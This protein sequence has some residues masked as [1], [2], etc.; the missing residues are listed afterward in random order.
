MSVYLKKIGW[1]IGLILLQVLILNN[2]HINGYATP[3][4]YIYFILKYNSGVNKNV[5]MLWAFVLGFIID[6]F[7]NTPGVNAAS[8]TFLAFIRNPI[9]KSFT[10]RDDNEDFDPSILTMRFWS[11]LKY[12][13]L[14]TL[15]FCIALLSINTFSFFNPL[16]LL[17]KILSDT[18]ITLI[19]ILC[20]EASR[21]RE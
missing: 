4:F 13:F 3:F 11:F 9:L 8:V 19:C 20:V 7:S 10:S 14:C 18:A 12:I 2:I 5:L 17:Y 16:I 21:R 15:I 6:V 1:F